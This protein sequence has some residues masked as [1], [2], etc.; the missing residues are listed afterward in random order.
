MNFIPIFKQN[1]IFCY[2][3]NLYLRAQ[4]L[5][6]KYFSVSINSKIIVKCFFENSLFY[7]KSGISCNIA[8]VNYGQRI[9]HGG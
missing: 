7:L 3:L 6:L 4:K 2:S 8:L 1:P 5:Y 9:H